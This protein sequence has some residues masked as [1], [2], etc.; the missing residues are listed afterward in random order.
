[1]KQNADS[2]PD[3]ARVVLALMDV[4][5][6][7]IT[8]YEDKRQGMGYAAVLKG[9]RFNV[10]S[11]CHNPDA[12]DSPFFYHA[13]EAGAWECFDVNHPGV[14]DAIAAVEA[15]QNDGSNG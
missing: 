8:T 14:R 12:T 3:P 1:M 9:V 15:E 2:V 13:T 5:W 11:W 7:Q 6:V 10:G 4:P